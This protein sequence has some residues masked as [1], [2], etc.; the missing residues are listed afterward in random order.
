M[1]QSKRC[2]YPLKEYL[3]ASVTKQMLD[4]DTLGDMKPFF[5][6]CRFLKMNASESNNIMVTG[7]LDSVVTSELHVHECV[8]VTTD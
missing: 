5:F 2:F 8:C 4:L 3:S 7:M 6:F 1:L